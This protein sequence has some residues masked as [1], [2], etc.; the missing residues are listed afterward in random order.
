MIA[1]TEGMGAQMMTQ[2]GAWGLAGLGRAWA[3]CIL[4]ACVTVNFQGERPQ[5]WLVDE[6]RQ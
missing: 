5:R 1:T 6:T 4:N 2:Q 3:H